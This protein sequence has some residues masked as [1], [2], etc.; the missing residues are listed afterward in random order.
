[1]ITISEIIIILVFS[2]FICMCCCI[3]CCT[4]FYKGYNHNNLE[5]SRMISRSFSPN[6]IS[7]NELNSIVPNVGI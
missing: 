5:R 7:Q 2:F 6:R 3:K 4:Y 1:M